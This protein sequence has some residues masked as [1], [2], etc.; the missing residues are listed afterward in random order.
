MDE[1]AAQV[2]RDI[3]TR[4]GRS[5]LDDVDR[6][7]AL[8]QDY[9]P[10]T[11]RENSALL[12]ALKAN[13]PRRFLVLPSGSLSEA[14]IANFAENLA[15]DTVLSAEA[16]RWAVLS[17]A[18]ALGLPIATSGPRNPGR[19]AG[20]NPAAPRPATPS[21]AGPN[22]ARSPP[23]MTR[24]RYVPRAGDV[25]LPGLEQAYDPQRGF[26]QVSARLAGVLIVGFVS[27]FGFVLAGVGAAG[28]G[29]LFAFVACGDVK[30]ENGYVASFGIA[31][32]IGFFVVKALWPRRRT[33]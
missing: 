13:I 22:D 26:L 6:C 12:E 29:L 1:A 7:Y 30:C 31:G 2:L 27:T 10:S 11:S 20:L 8:L 16:A 3:V 21:P 32:V 28:V 19:P 33:K 5:V 17:W 15:E 4:K 23:A 24:A 9:S 25:H 14:T 18:N